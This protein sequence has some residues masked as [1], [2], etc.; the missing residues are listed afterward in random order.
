MTRHPMLFHS[1]SLSNRRSIAN[2][3][4]SGHP[5]GFTLIEL[6]LALALCGIVLSAAFG[7]VHLSWKYRTAG[8]TQVVQAMLM[9]GVVQDITL[10]LR[11]AVVPPTAERFPSVQTQPA[12]LTDEVARALAELGG[13]ETVNENGL[14]DSR[15]P[16]LDVA[17]VD[18]LKPVHFY[19]AESCFVMLSNCRNSR[20]FATSNSR[21]TTSTSAGNRMSHVVWWWNSGAATRV[22]FSVRNDQLEFRTLIGSA[23]DRGLVRV[24]LG[25]DARGAHAGS[26][27][28]P[29][30]VT[31][32]HG[33]WTRI[34]DEVRRV[35]FRY[36]DGRQWRA[37]WNSH[38]SRRLPT[39]VELT[40]EIG[41][42]ADKQR[43]VIRLPQA[44]A[45]SR[46]L[47]EN[48]EAVLP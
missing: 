26:V 47:S 28:R 30:P 11:A 9:R 42:G 17:S 8:E 24:R 3:A 13:Q 46:P 16:V 44:V 6:L 7:A 18:R 21:R 36:S 23:D 48:R 32:A 39:A 4:G 40:L 43:M 22:P 45:G 41:P 1:G 29:G 25:F 31:V 20:F 38:L 27:G 34:N 37:S 5:D 10:D 35:S 33:D 14:T 15:Q 2:V 12:G 19:G